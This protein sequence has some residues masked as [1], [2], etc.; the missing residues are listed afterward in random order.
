MGFF[1]VD[2]M[3][4]SAGLALL[5]TFFL[6]PASTFAVALTAGDILVAVSP[7]SD[8][9]A[10]IAEYT[11]AGALVESWQM[12][13]TA[14]EV[15]GVA[16]DQNLT[17]YAYLGQGSSLIWS[18]NP[19]TGTSST[20][21]YPGLSMVGSTAVGQLVAYSHYLY[22]TDFD[23][24]GPST[25]PNGI[26][27]FDLSNS[28]AGQ[29]FFDPI[30]G[31]PTGDSDFDKV[32]VGL[33]GVLYGLQDQGSYQSIDLIESDPIAMGTPTLVTLPEETNALAVDAS[34]DFYILR[35]G[36]IDE[37][38]SSFQLLKTLS[39]PTSDYSGFANNLDLSANGT[40]VA[41]SSGGTVILTNTQLSSF[42]SFSTAALV[43]SSD[44]IRQT[45]STLITPPLAV[46]EPTSILALA[47]CGTFLSFRRKRR[48]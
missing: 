27:R 14:P 36:G 12:T 43:G 8:G 31:D 47:V 5:A 4:A 23:T 13:S 44:S 41:S 20:F 32:T 38:N 29:R 48:I 42:T 21:T 19:Q 6:L 33:N 28:D 16:V 2:R 37:Y 39:I 10:V 45:A 35:D 40:I 15:E 46:P 9:Y 34:G 22:A 17:P 26:V 24:G 1:G 3:R 7:N 30:P 11:P 25:A 18:V